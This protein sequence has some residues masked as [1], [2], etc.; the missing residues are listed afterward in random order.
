MKLLGAGLLTIALALSMAG[1][2]AAK[3]GFLELNN[4][5]GEHLAVGSQVGLRLTLSTKTTLFQKQYTHE[6][7]TSSTTPGTVLENG[8]TVDSLKGFEYGAN[9]CV[10][11]FGPEEE[12][13][14]NA[15][16]EVVL[17]AKGKATVYPS[18]GANYWESWL[19]NIDR[20]SSEPASS[21]WYKIEKQKGTFSAMA[22]T[23]VIEGTGKATEVK[24]NYR[25]NAACAVKI[26][27]AFTIELFEH[28]P[29]LET[30]LVPEL[31]P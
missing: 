10:G 9:S 4:Q 12:H 20:T 17:S 27:I 13:M 14:Y 26:P 28:Q 3:T 25:S 23:L 8:A 18:Q 5:S 11:G 29:E 24:K 19:L 15:A 2:A 30:P 22:A 16:R 1:G 21:C 6:C 31:V 7:S